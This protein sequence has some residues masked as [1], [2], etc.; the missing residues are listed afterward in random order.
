MH[1][2]SEADMAI[3]GQ[4]LKCVDTPVTVMG[5]YDSEVA[6]AFMVVFERCDSDKRKCKSEEEFQE[7]LLDKYLFTY[8]NDKK[9]I[10]YKFGEDRIDR[11][12]KRHWHTLSPV[13]RV[14]HVKMIYRSDLVLN[15]SI[16]SIG[17]YSD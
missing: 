9:F 10:S 15:D 8:E 14:E 7:W 2:D 17:Q 1:F 6:I 11:T 3:Y 4:K 12:A 5:N 13:S 16:F